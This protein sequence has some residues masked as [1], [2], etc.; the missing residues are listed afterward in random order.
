M[1]HA[2]ADE[3]RALAGGPVAV[4]GAGRVGRA[5]S[6][7]LR[8]AAVDVRGPLG[9]GDT[10]AGA[11]VVLLAVPDAE[12]AAAAAAVAPGPFVGHL[13]GATTLETLAGHEGFGLHPLTSVTAATTSF[14]RV[15]AAVAGTTPR[16]LAVA[17]ALAGVLGMS[18]LR[19]ADAD[20]AAYHAA[21]SIASNFLVTLEAFAE[22]LAATVG[23]DRAALGP[24]VRATVDNWQTLGAQR[25]L[26]GPIARGDDDTVSRQRAAV[27]ERVPHR[28]PLFDALTAATRELATTAAGTDRTAAAS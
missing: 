15:P 17:Q 21:A 12:I 28:L 4:V 9:R 23:L 2:N 24:L 13:S 1:P 11:A 7:A 10:T 14:A 3:L 6:S 8:A 19:I 18:P 5:V 22:E 27:A 20:R 26:T 25:A 16:A